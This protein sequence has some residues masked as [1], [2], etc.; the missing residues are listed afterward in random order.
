MRPE[1]RDNQ[2]AIINLLAGK[3]KP[4]QARLLKLHSRDAPMP[5]VM[6]LRFSFEKR[7]LDDAIRDLKD[8]Q[9]TYDVSWYMISMVSDPI[10]DLELNRFAAENPKESAVSKAINIRQSIRG[11]SGTSRHTFVPASKLD[12]AKAIGIRHS[13]ARLVPVVASSSQVLVDSLPYDEANLDL[14]TK[15][16]RNLAKRLSNSDPSSFAI[17]K[18]QGVV[19]TSNADHPAVFDLL[20]EIPK[21]TASEPQTVRSHLIKRTEHSLTERFDIAKQ[22]VKAISY[23][24]MLGFVHKNVRPE[25]LI[26]FGSPGASF[27]S[28]FLVGF[29][30]AR[31]ADGRTYRR[32]DSEWS[33]DLYRHPDRQGL[34]PSEDYTMQHDIYSLGVCLL[35]IGLWRTFVVYK[36]DGN[37]DSVTPTEW[38]GLSVEALMRKS[39]AS[40]KRLLIS[41]AEHNLPA[42][43]GTA[44]TKIVVNCL[45]CLDQDNE[46]F[47]DK[48]EFQDQDGV[49]VGVRYIEKVRRRIYLDFMWSFHC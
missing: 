26:G 30:Q 36:D 45:T 1:Y 21:N 6:R 16:I 20:F 39:P 29:E 49:L 31:A 42:K 10:V 37:A 13:S 12:Y 17:L 38:F 24:H 22:A 14:M 4:V 28:F 25:N 41:A 8:W 35:E 43:M 46:D 18:C 2:E 48:S 40:K 32:S 23:V 19:K 7:G 44:Y 11:H 15:N 33:R 3:L 34:T 5:A 47:G 27:G 9:Q